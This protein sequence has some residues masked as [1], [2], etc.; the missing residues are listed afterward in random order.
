Q[1]YG[2]GLR[3][4]FTIEDA[5]SA[6]AQSVADRA[7]AGLLDDVILPYDALFGQEKERPADIRGLT[8]AA[9]AHFER[10]LRDS[11][12]IARARQPVFIGVHA[13]WLDV[14]ESVHRDLL[15]EWKDSRLVWLPLQLALTPNQYDEQV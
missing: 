9:S 15:A 4:A 14:I 6:K 8:S 10:W 5:D 11:S 3:Q 12:G 7:R 1:A 2:D 13:R